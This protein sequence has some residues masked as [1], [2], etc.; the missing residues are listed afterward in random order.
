MGLSPSEFW[1]MTVAEFFLEMEHHRPR[2]R[3]DFAG[4]LTLGQVEEISAWMET[5]TD[6]PAPAAPDH[7]G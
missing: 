7:H 6:E 3:G 4:R 1:S 5:W 2:G